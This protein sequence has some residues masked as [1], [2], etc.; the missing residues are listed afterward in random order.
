MIATCPC[1]LRY[2][3]S[4]SM[5]GSILEGQRR[6]TL[7]GELVINYNEWVPIISLRRLSYL[8]RCPNKQ[9]WQNKS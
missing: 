4:L 9:T 3:G 5:Q 6:Y 1:M 8:E 2:T 7:E